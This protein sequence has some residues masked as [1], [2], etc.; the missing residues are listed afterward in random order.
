[1]RHN[2]AWKIVCFVIVAF[3]SLHASAQWGPATGHVTLIDP[4]GMGARAGASFPAIVFQIDQPI[5]GNPCITSGGAPATLMFFP[6]SFADGTGDAAH[7]AGNDQQMVNSKA[8]LSTLQLALAT[9][10]SVSLLGYN[11]ADGFC[12]IY[13][14]K[15][16]NQ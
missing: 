12:Q 8:V 2:V 14:I 11:G 6:I 16:L 1:M 4:S 9:G 10:Y 13:N 3:A 5:A 7:P 15:I